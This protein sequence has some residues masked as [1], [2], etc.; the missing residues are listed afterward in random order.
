M[1]IDAQ[2]AS[3]EFQHPFL[4]KQQ[5]TV[6]VI[7]NDTSVTQRTVRGNDANTAYLKSGERST[8]CNKENGEDIQD[9][10]TQKSQK[11]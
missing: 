3:D 8:E 5:A 11:N 2:K 9:N 6:L 1:S 4:I 7:K 10:S